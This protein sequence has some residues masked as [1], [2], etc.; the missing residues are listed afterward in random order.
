MQILTIE[1]IAADFMQNKKNFIAKDVALT[2]ELA[3]AAI[4]TQPLIGVAAAANPLFAQFKT[5]EI[6]GEQM[7]LPTE[8][9]SGAQTIISFFFPFTAIIREGNK[10]YWDKPSPSWLHGRIEGQE[11]IKAFAQNMVDKIKAEGYQA[12]APSI[13][14]R[15]ASQHGPK[16]TSNWSERHAAYACGLGTFSLSKGLITEKGVAGRFT[17]VI[18]NAQ[19]PPTGKSFASYD[20]NCIKCGQCAKNCPAG[21]I[22]LAKGKN[23]VIC[24]AYLAQIKKEFV[25]R[26]GCGKCQVGVPCET[27]NPRSK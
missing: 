22:S 18:T 15:F 8:W 12:M 14:A 9:L 21:A 10:Q 11:F 1:K 13:D 6:V 23:H 24:N 27:R 4:F 5:P 3:N 20:A 26:Y 19:L 7:L 16:F 2:K 17:S 25:P